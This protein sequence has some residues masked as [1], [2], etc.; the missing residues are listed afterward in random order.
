MLVEGGP[1]GMPHA[2][3]ARFLLGALR[4]RGLKA[5]TLRSWAQALGYGF[6]FLDERGVDYQIRLVM[7]EFLSYEELTAFS[8]HC[9]RQRSKHGVIGDG[10]AAQ[11]YNRFIEFL[12]WSSGPI[13]ARISDD[14]VRSAARLARDD[15]RVQANT[16]APRGRSGY[17]DP[18]KER[19]GLLEAQREQL[20]SV[21]IPGN[22]ENPFQPELQHRN[23]AILELLY[24]SG[25]RAGELLAL[26]IRNIDFSQRPA[27]LTIQRTHDDP[28]DP[29]K[30]QPVQKTHGRVL[31]L[32][33]SL[34]QLLDDWIL[35]FRADRRCFPQ[36]RKH[37]FIFV[38]KSGN[39]LSD[40]GFRK[41]FETL[42]TRHP[43]L[44]ALT[45]HIF[46]HDWNDRWIEATADQGVDI[47]TNRREQCYAMGW[48]T[49]SNMPERYARRAIRKLTNNRI[50][51][52]QK[53]SVDY[54][55]TDTK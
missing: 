28:E 26:K 7:G 37:S 49:N 13:I 6:E 47:M 25:L 32:K 2:E 34:A 18:A 46:R 48:S 40:R 15:F 27:T 17:S 54:R 43:V 42:R 24:E 41:I 44:G 8:D 3:A 50:L 9:R 14:R 1:S 19:L 23:Q 45:A 16:L 20:R 51:D 29:R 22:P 31:E 38:N 21:I 35:K 55:G 36:A 30:Q 53:R 11:K 5:N 52:L 39:P 10:A 4:P 12:L 33:E